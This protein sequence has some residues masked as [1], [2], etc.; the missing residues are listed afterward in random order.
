MRVKERSRWL[1]SLLQKGGFFLRSIRFHLTLWYVLTVGCL[2]LVFG[3]GVYLLQS[4][5]IANNVDKAIDVRLHEEREQLATLAHRGLLSSTCQSLQEKGLLSQNGYDVVAVFDESLKLTLSCRI[6]QSREQE[7]LLALLQERHREQTI[8]L[9][10]HETLSTGSEMAVDTRLLLFSTE[11]TTHR[12][13][14]IIIGSSREKIQQDDLFLLQTLFLPGCLLLV[15]A[16][17]GGYCFAFK[18]LHPIRVITCI[19]REIKETDLHRRLNLQRSDELGELA[20]TFDQMIARLETGFDRQRQFIAITSHELR[21]PLTIVNLE[22]NQA[23]SPHVTLEQCQQSLEVIRR[24]NEHMSCVVNQ[25]LLLARAD[26]QQF[27][28]QWERLDLSGLVL[29]VVERL[30]P[31]AQELG[32]RIQWKDLPELYIQADLSTLSCLVTNLVENAIKY[33]SGYGDTICIYTYNMPESHTSWAVL[34]IQDNGPGIDQKHLPHIFDRF[35]RINRESLNNEQMS[36]DTYS[37][38]VQRGAGLGLSIVNW[39]AQL[40]HGEVLVQ[41]HL[42]SGSIFE[43]KFP[44]VRPPATNSKPISDYSGSQES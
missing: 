19:A 40:H 37:Y 13:L 8:N 6:F 16:M 23:L 29:D 2:A 1:S 39:V 4:R 25:L 18:V 24:E 5:N 21:T 10:L 11:D 7:Q 41:S 30:V 36:K 42:G 33:T 32:I 44:L 22:V 38:R 26:A 3:S 31:L 12:P 9:P 34:H 20:M 17:I 15:L 14:F 43:V 35:Y 28:P 27:T